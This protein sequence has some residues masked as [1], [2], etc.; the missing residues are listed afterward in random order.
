MFGLVAWFVLILYLWLLVWATKRGWRWGIEKRGW[1]GKKRYLGAMIGFMIVYLPVFWDWLPTVAVHQYYCAKDSGFW[2]YKTLDQWKAENP[3]VMDTLVANKVSVQRIGD[4][5]NHT[6][7]VVRNQRF[8]SVVQLQRP[9]ALLPVY[10]STSE[11]VDS[12]NGEILAR[13]V[14]YS[15]GKGRDYFKFWLNAQGC[16]NGS[17]NRIAFLSFSEQLERMTN[18]IQGGVK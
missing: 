13:Y 2:V 12:S 9:L 11:I 15:S 8:N 3:G 10:S 5:E 16:P 6:D 17:V 1:T 14:D 4:D 18:R 7:T